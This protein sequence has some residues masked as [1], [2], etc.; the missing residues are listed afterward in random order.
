MLSQNVAATVPLVE[1]ML[2]GTVNNQNCENNC[3][4]SQ[5]V[6]VQR[7]TAVEWINND[8]VPHTLVSGK[9]EDKNNGTLFDSGQIWVGKSVIHDFNYVGVYHYFEKDHPQNT[10]III[11]T[12]DTYPTSLSKVITNSNATSSVLSPLE[13]FKSGIKAED[14][15][16]RQ[17]LSLVFKLEDG[18]P[19]CVKPNTR[20]Q[21]LEKGWGTD[22]EVIKV[23]N[24]NASVAY[25][26]NNGNILS[27]TAYG[28]SST[29]S[30]GEIS[31]S[32]ILIVSMDTTSNGTLIITMPRILIDARSD[33]HDDNFTILSNGQEIPYA[34]TS[35]TITSRTLS[36]PYQ[37]G[38]KHIEII[39]YGYYNKQPP[40]T[41]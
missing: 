15:K 14:V 8:L 22:L 9:P 3:V 41:E 19:A 16:C 6:T 29:S 27:V 23:K 36:I 17:D 13:Q 11:V 38:V 2:S 28:L 26:I 4:I 39:G 1:I 7:G 10:G 25:G 34:E 35:K 18:T 32:S 40:P 20:T 31:G 24:A 30:S 5:T 33:N 37:W 21:L 12:D